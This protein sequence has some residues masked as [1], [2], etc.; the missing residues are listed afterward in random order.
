ME[1]RAQLRYYRSSPRKVR[2]LADMVRGHEVEPA[3]RSLRLSDKHAARDVAKV[4]RSALANLEQAQPGVD[5]D[6]VFISAITVDDGP[7][8]RRGRPASKWVRMHRIL[9]RMCHITV[10][11]AVRES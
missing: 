1:S 11:L 10:E 6:K 7:R 5:V 9:R 4:V 3:L 8:M 2:L